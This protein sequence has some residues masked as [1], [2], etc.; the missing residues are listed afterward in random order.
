M[1]SLEQVKQLNT[2]V[3]KTIEYVRQLNEEN[4]TLKIKL[5]NNQKRLDELEVL[6]TR[7]KEEQGRIEDGILSALDR[8]NQFESAVEK[9][10]AMRTGEQK[11]PKE[12]K[13]GKPSG[14]SSKPVPEQPAPDSDTMP[15]S[16]PEA[17]KPD[18]ETL[19]S[20]PEMEVLSEA[21]IDV[22]QEDSGEALDGELDIF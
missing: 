11:P 12:G 1:L 19:D 2:K 17:N 20:S 9:S 15:E 22:G 16:T 10:L 6:V 7:F 14:K 8:L 21:D 4:A 18:E 5:E 3:E 13:S